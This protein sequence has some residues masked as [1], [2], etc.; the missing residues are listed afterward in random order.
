MTA[1]VGVAATRGEEAGAEVTIETIDEAEV[2]ASKEGGAIV[3]IAMTE[4]QV[5][6]VS[7]QTGGGLQHRGQ[8]HARGVEQLL[9]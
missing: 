5:R 8:G 2:V 9:I 4:E 7:C 6:A 3:A 1:G